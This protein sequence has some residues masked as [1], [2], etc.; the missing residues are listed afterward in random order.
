M[1]IVLDSGEFQQAPLM[2]SRM[3]EVLV[4]EGLPEVV[5]SFIALVVQLVGEAAHEGLEVRKLQG[6]PHVL[7][8]VAVKG[9]K[10]HPEGA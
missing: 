1:A 3:C 4:L 5:A 9:V 10:V 8:L 7:V 2:D 6:L